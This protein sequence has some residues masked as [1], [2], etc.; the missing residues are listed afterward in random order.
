MK[1]MKEG[2]E[3]RFAET[4]D[5][6]V[7]AEELSQLLTL[8]VRAPLRVFSCFFFFRPRVLQSICVALLCSALLCVAL[9]RSFTH[10][11]R[12]RVLT[13]L[14]EGWRRHQERQGGGRGRLPVQQVDLHSSRRRGTCR[15][16][17][18]CVR[19]PRQVERMTERPGE[20]ANGTGKSLREKKRQTMGERDRFARGGGS[21]EKGKRGERGVG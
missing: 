9:H 5:S 15:R 21:C 1:R 7:A 17:G 8:I 18:G 19:Q 20:R 16:G 10:P 3:I 13:P 6:Q 14:T 12:C 4:P 11:R 2:H